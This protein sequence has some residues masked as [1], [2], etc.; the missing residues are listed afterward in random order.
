L[1]FLEVTGDGKKL[2]I[3]VTMRQDG[4]IEGE[5][6]PYGRGIRGSAKQ[7]SKRVV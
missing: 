3:P 6:T 4:S 2:A 5:Q 1:G 7:D